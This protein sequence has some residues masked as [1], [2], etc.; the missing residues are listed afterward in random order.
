MKNIF[1]IL[2]FLNFSFVFSQDDDDFVK[3][4]KAINN[5]TI[6][7]YN[8][9]GVEFSSQTFS[10]EFSEKGLK[11]LYKKYDIKD[12]DVKIKDE[13]LSFNNFHIAKSEKITD[14]INQVNSY[15][16]VENK[17]KTVTIIW[18]GY[19][20]KVDKEFERKYVNRIL[21]N[22]IPKEV[23]EETIIGSIDFAGRKIELGSNCYWTNINTVQC[24][25]Y[26]EMNWSVHRTYVSAKN[27]I[28]NQFNITKSK[29]GGKVISEE[30]VDVIFEGTDT[31]AK[32]VV[33][34]FTG[35]KSLL[36]GMSGG[37]TLTIYYVACE[38]RG[39]YVSC[40]MSFWDNDT[41]TENGLAPLLEEVMQLKK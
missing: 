25:Y 27:S 34:D 4:L 28:D 1:Y 31:K 3:R 18:F 11:K 29:K 40:C 12:T 2:F 5:K 7:F 38:V 22:E 6:I 41:I 21:N 35:V 37:K 26:G 24:P 39:N 20:N 15:Y 32:K 33:Y 19:F 36:A 13:N 8:V 9:D 16:F 30:E 10:N 14:N 23:F 17:N